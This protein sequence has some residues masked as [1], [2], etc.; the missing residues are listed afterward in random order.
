MTN[1]Q[2]VKASTACAFCGE[3]EESPRHGG[4]QDNAYNHPYVAELSDAELLPCPL[5]GGRWVRTRRTL[6]GGTW[7]QC[8]SCFC[9]T[10]AGGRASAIETWNRRASTGPVDL[11]PADLTVK[12]SQE[13][14]FEGFGAYLAGSVNDGPALVVLNIGG[15]A[16][17]VQAGD[18]EKAD[19]PYLIAETVM[20][21][22][23]HALEEWAGVEFNEER[24]E[25]LV[26]M[27]RERYGK[28]EWLANAEG[29]EVQQSTKQEASE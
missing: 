27:Y 2:G 26:E 1:D 29:D 9:S 25:K 14:W 22:V 16:A 5:C 4:I 23:V 24:V 21:E 17:L 15:I 6:E 7:V 19:V 28:E 12:V 3:A 18:I 13:D 8:Q 11:L 10:A 20:H